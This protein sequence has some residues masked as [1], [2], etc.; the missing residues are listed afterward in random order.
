MVDV[1]GLFVGY[2]VQH[3]MVESLG[4]VGAGHTAIATFDRHR[5]PHF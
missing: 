4:Y 3:V 2:Y 1:I 5:S